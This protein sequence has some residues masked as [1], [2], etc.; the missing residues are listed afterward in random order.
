VTTKIEEKVPLIPD[1]VLED[2]GSRPVACCWKMDDGSLTVS[3]VIPADWNDPGAWGL[4]LA[5][6]AHHVAQAY[7]PIYP[8]QLAGEIKQRIIDVFHAELKKPTDRPTGHFIGLDGA[9]S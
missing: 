1:V 7:T 5:D 4:L 6:L 2:D 9:S 3:L 8:N